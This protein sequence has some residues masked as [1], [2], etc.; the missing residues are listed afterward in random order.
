MAKTKV[1]KAKSL[2]SVFR[3]E[4]IRHLVT[5]EGLSL[6][7]NLCRNPVRLSAFIVDFILMLASLSLLSLLTLFSSLSPPFKYT[8]IGLA[9]FLISTFY[10]MYFELAWQGRTPGKKLFNLRVVKRDGSELSAASLVARN[11]TREVEIFLPIG[12]FFTSLAD[13]G[14][15]TLFY[16]LWN[17]ILC[18]FPLFNRNRLRA[19]DLIGG[20]MVI[21]MPKSILLEDLTQAQAK[22]Q[23]DGFIFS[24][25]Q[26]AIYG[27]KEL[28]T[29]E[30]LLRKS[31]SGSQIS[32][33][34]TAKGLDLVCQKICRK[35]GWSDPVPPDQV[36]KFLTAFYLSER[37]QLE[38]G[39]MYG[40]HKESKLDPA[41]KIGQTTRVDKSP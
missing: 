17:I 15:K 40:M 18:L 12:L 14:P 21:T 10:F 2:K 38:K 23:D 11:L 32:R 34:N 25:Q 9:F 5:P 3:P 33:H 4:D 35:I 27:K 20:T 28:Q 24:Q 37:A 16:F 29:L 22:Y 13:P 6:E 41:T 31:Q 7:L 39:L 30:K 8:C 19:G 36:F 1:K 26:L